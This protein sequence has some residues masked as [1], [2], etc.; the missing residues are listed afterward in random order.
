MSEHYLRQDN[1]GFGEKK[2]AVLTCLYDQR[3]VC[4]HLV[5]Q[6]R[7]TDSRM[8]SSGGSTSVQS[9]NFSPILQNIRIAEKLSG[10]ATHH[11]RRATGF[12]LNTKPMVLGLVACSIAYAVPVAFHFTQR[13]TPSCSILEISPGTSFIG[14]E[15][16]QKLRW[17]PV[18]FQYGRPTKDCEKI[19]LCMYRSPH[20]YFSLLDCRHLLL[21]QGSHRQS[22]D[23]AQSYP[24]L[25]LHE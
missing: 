7:V 3:L 1:D 21:E 4:A 5:N 19:Y 20:P 14:S 16:P 2:I 25:S 10:T 15:T 17:T 11:A 23:P 13:S 6:Y 24:K 12:E 18:G 9:K 8:V 22:P